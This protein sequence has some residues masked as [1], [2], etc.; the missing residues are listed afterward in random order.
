MA[1]TTAS[2]PS[3]RPLFAR[4]V[5]MSRCTAS[6]SPRSSQRSKSA[7]T[8]SMT[9]ACQSDSTAPSCPTKIHPDRHL[10]VVLNPSVLSDPG[11]GSRLRRACRAVDE[12]LRA[13]SEVL[14]VV[15]PL[16]KIPI[17]HPVR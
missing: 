2:H 8:G 3:V 10:C 6:V 4:H 16:V 12:A 9:D 1:V 15:V 14:P 5:G 7:S 17:L 13:A 11:A